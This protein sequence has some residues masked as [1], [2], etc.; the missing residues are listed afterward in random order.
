MRVYIVGG[1]GSGKTSLARALSHATGIAAVYL[2]DH[3]DRTYAR[4]ESGEVTP[5][6]I[7]YRE[8]L[9]SEQ[10]AQP[11][12]IIEGAEPPLLRAFAEASDLIIWCDVPFWVAAARM[13]RRHVI[14]D[15]TRSNQ[16]PGYR[17]L[18]R[19]LRSVRRRYAA[20]MD[21]NAG[22]WTKWTRS[23]LRQAIGPYAAKTLRS[24]GGGR[25]DSIDAALKCASL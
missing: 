19:F 9:V 12:W 18:W 13:I 11:D 1:P 3:W 4:D 25:R 7:T 14:A 23:W 5:E 15:L 10:L 20:P 21:P 24:R 2:D 16:F 22:E 6:A 8:R 17:R